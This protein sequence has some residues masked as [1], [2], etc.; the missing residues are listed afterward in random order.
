VRCLRI[1]A[2]ASLLFLASPC[3]LA[4]PFQE[5][6]RERQSG[7]TL[8]AIDIFSALRASSVEPVARARAAGELGATLLQARRLDEAR[9]MLLEAVS[10]LEGPAR[11]R[12]QLDLATVAAQA[13]RPDEARALLEQ[14]ASNPDARTAA[15]ARLNLARVVPASDRRAHLERA[16]G[17]VTRIADE[18]ERGRLEL[19]LGDQWRRL[20]G[21]WTAAAYAHLASALRLAKAAGDARLQA[22]ALD[23][24]SAAYESAGRA[25]E[26]LA[27]AQEALEAARMLPPARVADLAIDLEWRVGRLAHALGDEAAALAAYQRA[28]QNVESV[29]GDIPIEYDDGRSSYRVTLEPVYL[30]YADLLFASLAALPEDEKQRRLVRI[31]DVIELARQAELQ[32]YLRDRCE[33]EAI[34][35]GPRSGVGKGVAVLYPIVFDE[36]I[37]L[38]LETDGGITWRTTRVAAQAVRATA[39]LFAHDLR[40]GDDGYLPAARALHRWLLAPLEPQLAERGVDTLIVVPEGALRLVAMGALHDGRQFAIEK[41]AIG[42]VTGL[43]LTNTAAPPDAAPRALVAGLSTPGPVVDKLP[44]DTVDAILGVRGGG[45]RAASTTELRRSLELP[46]VKDE[47]Q[48]IARILDGHSLLDSDFT[49]RAFQSQAQSGEYRIVHVASHGVFG[50]SADASYIMAFDDVLSMNDLQALLRDERLRRK[51]IELLS[52]SACQSAEGDER[53][54]LGISG[55]AMKARAKSVLGTLWPVEDTAARV[56]MEGFYGSLARDRLNKVRA[57]QHAQ[58]EAMRDPRFGH[59]F[60]WAPFVLIGNW[61]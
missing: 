14:I 60:F 37:E 33:V 7:N 17:L 2:A 54:P 34:Q 38:L 35:R 53:S 43:T 16:A 46:G 41:Y 12:Y 56:V 27:L 18:R 52:L 23:S 28:V 6:A 55:A 26:A 10:G 47:V 19:N 49:A 39:R 51:P 32:D 59:P 22:E 1:A 21:E 15:V 58:R 3:A 24:L 29:R 44:S 42:T 36:R 48:A 57:L 8:R 11:A 40:N 25:R 61:L 4:D 50:G 20:G 45:S 31:R 30:G 9:A 13:G 5:G